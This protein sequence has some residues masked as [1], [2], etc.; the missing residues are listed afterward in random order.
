MVLIWWTM[1]AFIYDNCQQL[2]KFLTSETVRERTT[3]SG[4]ITSG[5]LCD[6]KKSYTEKVRPM[7]TLILCWLTKS[8]NL[9]FKPQPDSKSANQE[10]FEF[11]IF[12]ET[13]RWMNAEHGWCTY[14]RKWC[15]YYRKTLFCRHDGHKWVRIF[16][17]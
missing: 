3:K 6:G 8:R 4:Q 2:K 14:W 17:R 15:L 12:W 7:F 16:E 13:A 10:H 9:S 11:S 1:I 5:S